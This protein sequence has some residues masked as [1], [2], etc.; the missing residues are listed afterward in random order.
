MHFMSLIV[1]IKTIL[2]IH[3]YIYIYV[4]NYNNNVLSLFII[5]LARGT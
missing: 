1:H 4:Y 2:Y 5:G 3:T